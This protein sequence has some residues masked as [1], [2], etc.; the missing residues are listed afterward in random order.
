MFSTIN[1]ITKDLRE[2]RGA[3]VKIFGQPVTLDNE[4][5]DLTI[6][7]IEVLESL[8]DYEIDP[9][10]IESEG[11]EELLIEGKGDNTY[12]WS[13]PVSNDLDFRFYNSDW[14]DSVYVAIKAHR[15]GDVRGNYTDEVMLHFD[16]IDCF[17]EA[18]TETS[19]TFEFEV[20]GHEYFGEVN[21]LSETY[22]I[23]DNENGEYVCNAYG[24]LEDVIEKVKEEKGV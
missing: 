16:N 4:V 22:E 19:K 12:N 20:D 13:A 11:L 6:D 14:D 8:T 18:I 9:D 7:T 15:Y 17:Y 2:L 3:N 1:E 24:D 21:I 23:F 5:D 10:T